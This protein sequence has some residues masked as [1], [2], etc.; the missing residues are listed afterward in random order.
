MDKEHA[1]FLLQSYRPD[2]ADAQDSDFAEALQLAAEDRD[3]G[4]WLA[5]EHS[6]KKNPPPFGHMHFVFC[7]YYMSV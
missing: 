3:L 2:G 5:N 1:K 6:M 7:K 4:E